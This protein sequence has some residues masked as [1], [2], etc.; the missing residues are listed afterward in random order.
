MN[1][2]STKPQ[3][4]QKVSIVKVRN[5]INSEDIYYS[6]SD[7]PSKQIDGVEFIPVKLNLKDPYP[8]YVRKDSFDTLKEKV[9]V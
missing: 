6:S 4:K 3:Q 9:S 1:K 7:W 2:S 5:K 8:K